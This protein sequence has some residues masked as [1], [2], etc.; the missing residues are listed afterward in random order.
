MAAVL[1]IGE[2]CAARA[3]LAEAIARHVRPD[4]EVWAAGARPSHVRPEVRRVL[5]EAGIPSGGLRARSMLEI[6]M[7]DVKLVVSLCLEHRRPRLPR[8]YDVVSRPLADP[9]CAPQHE[10]EEA[11]RACR[12]ALIDRLPRLLDHHLPS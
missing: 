9:S 6:D 11:Y 7:E 12:D 10:R 8:R 1:F 5:D 4:L 2:A 3:P